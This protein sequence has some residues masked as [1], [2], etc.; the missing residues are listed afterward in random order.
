MQILTDLG[1]YRV[2]R[3]YEQF[4]V[5]KEH[6]AMRII[7]YFLHLNDVIVTESYPMENLRGILDWLGR[8]KILSVFYL[9]NE[10]YQAQ[11]HPY[12]KPFTEVRAVL[13]LYQCNRLTMRLNNSKGTIQRKVNNILWY[14]K[15]KDVLALL[16][17]T[18]IGTNT[19][20]EHLDS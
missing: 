17:D 15:S 10:F 4:F 9:K 12:S 7:S 6:V 8:K 13:G 16:D 3:G 2:S 11:L 18:S 19:K 20:R 1:F 14:E 5:K